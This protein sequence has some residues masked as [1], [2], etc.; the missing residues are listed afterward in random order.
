VPYSVDTKCVSNSVFCIPCWCWGT[1]LNYRDLRFW[2]HWWWKFLPYGILLP[3][4][5]FEGAQCRHLQG[6]AVWQS[7]WCSWLTFV[8][9]CQSTRHTIPE[10]ITLNL[11]YF[12]IFF[13]K[14]FLVVLSKFRKTSISFVMSVRLSVRMEQLDSNW[15]NFHEIWHLR[16]FVKHAEKIQV[17]LQ[18]D[19]NEECITGRLKSTFITS[20]SYLLRKRNVWDKRCRENQNT[21]FAFSNF[22]FFDNR[23]VYEIMWKNIVERAGHRWQYGACALR[24]GYL[25]LQLKLYNTHCFSIATM[26]ARTRLL[27]I[28]YVHWLSSYFLNCFLLKQTV[29]HISFSTVRIPRKFLQGVSFSRQR[30]AHVFKHMTGDL[31]SRVHDGSVQM[32]S[33]FID[34]ALTTLILRRRSS[35]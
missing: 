1:A 35:L 16:G 14:A 12:D 20:C 2:R 3:F 25:R 33:I 13:F 6:Q 18:L 15:A 32:T 29:I 5:H 19:T 24:A 9:C 34:T 4:R 28:S 27:V 8:T 23:A 7:A 21:R 17:S 26:V 11:I 30:F 10:H 22:F 31:Y